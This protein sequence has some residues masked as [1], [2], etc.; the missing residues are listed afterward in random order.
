MV[1]QVGPGNPGA[2]CIQA[3]VFLKFLPFVDVA[4]NCLSFCWIFVTL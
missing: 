2:S 3:L 4:E 1:P